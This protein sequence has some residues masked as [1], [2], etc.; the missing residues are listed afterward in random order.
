MLHIT[1]HI[2]PFHSFYIRDGTQATPCHLQYCYT[3]PFMFTSSDMSGVADQMVI[4]LPA[5]EVRDAARVPGT[6]TE[7]LEAL[8][9]G[10]AQPFYFV[11]P[12]KLLRCSICVSLSSMHHPSISPSSTFIHPASTQ[13]LVYHEPQVRKVWKSV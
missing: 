6:R 4:V 7:L 5:Y 13:Y 2:T 8:A 9:E 3:M 12:S 11:L 1:T 10:V